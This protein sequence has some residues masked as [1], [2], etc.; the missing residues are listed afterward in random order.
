MILKKINAIS[1]LLSAPALFVHIIFNVYCYLTMY[2]NPALKQLTSLPFMIFV[3]V[4]A[5]C[6]MLTLFLLGDGTKLDLYPKKNA[7]TV[8]QRVSAA[9]IF[10]MLIV[11][12]KSFDLLSSAASEGKWTMFG[13]L[14][15]VQVLFYA[16]VLTHTAVSFSKSLITLGILSSKKAMN[17]V[18][19]IMYSL[20]ALTFAL[21]SFA[22]VKGYIAM[23]PMFTSGGAV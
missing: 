13:A 18:D 12:L 15:A 22:I 16:V 17:T 3:I 11:H 21:A 9:L 19:Y 10:P 23:I 1:G 2:Y 20:C 4:H 7:R 14:L 5:I 6:G 8:L